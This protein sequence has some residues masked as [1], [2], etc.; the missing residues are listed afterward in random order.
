MILNIDGIPGGEF[1]V[2]IRMQNTLHRLAI[3]HGDLP[4]HHR[5]VPVG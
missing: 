1:A 3:K 5:R 2:K 4:V